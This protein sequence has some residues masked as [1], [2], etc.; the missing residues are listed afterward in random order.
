MHFHHPFEDF[1]FEIPD[2]WWKEANANL[3]K[4]SAEAFVAL[5][6]VQ[7]PT[8]L[9][10]IGEV[11]APR[12]SPGVEGLGRERT[13]SVLRAIIEG[14]PLPPLEVHRSPDALR[15]VVRDGFHRYFASVALGYPLLPVS[16]RPYF[17]LNTL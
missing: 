14:T 16:I 5:S 7:W 13:I 9:V 10:P 2:V 15:L 3:H 6:D 11:A 17:D 4:H 8:V 1:Q 12:R